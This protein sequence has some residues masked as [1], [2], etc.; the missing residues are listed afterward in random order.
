MNLSDF[1]KM[2]VPVHVDL[3][4]CI[5]SYSQKASCSQCV[6]F[7]PHNAIKMENGH[8][9]V[10]MCDGCGKCIQA[11]PLDVFEMDFSKALDSKKGPLFMACKKENLQDL[12]V[13]MTGCLQQFTWL[14][15]A[16]LIRNYGDVYI[17]AEK[18]MCDA[19]DF[20]WF[21]EG[22]IAL[23]ERYGLEDYTKR[24][25]II[26]DREDFQL[27]LNEAYGQINTRREYMLNQIGSIKN[28]AKNYTQ[29]SLEGYLTAFNDAWKHH[30]VTFEKVQSHA[31]LLNELYEE[32]PQAE[33][34]ELPIKAL[35]STQ[36]RFCH[37]CEKLCP[38]EAIAIIEED[39]HAVLAHHDVLCARC[40]L[41]I[42]IC[43]E[44]GLLWDRGLTRE[45]IANPHWRMLQ[46]GV[47]KTC[48]VCGE[49]FYPT[50]DNQDV[51]LICKNKI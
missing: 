8:I 35:A 30:R 6:R 32:S 12:P 17:F 10:E 23:M 24:L 38:W 15:L 27:K 33:N 47:A 2:T 21:P 4:R 44:K 26:R 5:H 22:Q 49:T 45:N 11:C 3:E 7:C 29:Q 40:G 34:E 48:S 37:I 9:T 31:L 25:H 46:Q 18:S 39:G 1:V 36:C 13:L 16:I 51:C 19:C 50:T 28:V 42:D 20:Q 14:Q 41:C 43:P